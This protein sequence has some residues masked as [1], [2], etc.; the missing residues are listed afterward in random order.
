MCDVVTVLV[1]VFVTLLVTLVLQN[2]EKLSSMCT[3]YSLRHLFVSVRS[4]VV[5]IVNG[6]PDGS[7]H[8]AVT[9]YLCFCRHCKLILYQ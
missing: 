3:V 7:I 8:G 9:R 4:G 6:T 5:L 1:T 2:K